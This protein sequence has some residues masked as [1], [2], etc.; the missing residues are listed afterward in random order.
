MPS[1]ATRHQRVSRN[2][3]FALHLY[4]ADHGLE[5]VLHAP[6]DVILDDTTVDQPDI[7][8]VARER[9]RIVTR[10]ALEVCRR[11]ARGLRHVSTHTP[12]RQ[13]WPVRLPP[14]S[15]STSRRSGRTD[16]RL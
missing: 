10:R 9:A 4:V 15:R 11:V 1:P 13:R 12:A 16:G 14:G 8:F 6:L 2:L 3:E 7:V 5:E